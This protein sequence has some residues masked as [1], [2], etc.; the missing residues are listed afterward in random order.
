M[1]QAERIIEKGESLEISTKVSSW[2]SWAGCGGNERESVDGTEEGN[3]GEDVE[4]CV[5]LATGKELGDLGAESRRVIVSSWLHSG[6][7]FYIIN[8]WATMG[9]FF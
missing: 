9:I 7:P 8:N 1:F 2:V 6:N 3:Q 4:G 5:I